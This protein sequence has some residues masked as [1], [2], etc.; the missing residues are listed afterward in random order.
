M[1]LIEEIN[2]DCLQISL[3]IV[4]VVDN[5][6]LNETIDVENLINYYIMDKQL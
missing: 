6:E 2:S 5:V 4:I 3:D 1:I